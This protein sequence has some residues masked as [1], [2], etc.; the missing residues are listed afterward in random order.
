MSI[1]ALAS[2]AA[3]LLSLGF[4]AYLIRIARNK[5]WYDHQ[6]ERKIHDG[7]IPRLGGA[8]FASAYILVVLALSV[9]GITQSLGLRI[10][11]VLVALP[12][13]LVFGVVD[14]FRP[15]RPR[16]KLLVQSIAALL[17]L[18][19]QFIF[20]RLS[21]TSIG[22]TIPFGWLGYPITFFWLVGV[23]NAVN[24]ID[25]VDGLAGGVSVIIAVFLA[26][27]FS[28][29]GNTAA[30]ILCGVLAATIVGFLVFNLP[31]PKAKIFMGDGGSQFLGFTL[32]MLPLLDNGSGEASL[33]LP[34]AAALLIVP[35]FDTFMAIWRRLRDGRRIDSADR[36]HMHHKLMNLGLGARGVDA[37][38]Y[39]LQA[40]VGMLVYLSVTS[41]GLMPLFYL[42]GAYALALT[43][44][45][46]LHYLNRTVMA[47][48]A[49]AKEAGR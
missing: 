20:H 28:L 16:Y 32:A 48:Q 9:A 5:N 13:I 44:F 38:V 23:T 41:T 4:V 33:P 12:L 1:Y 26:A 15:L 27:V 40:T 43:F 8:G 21:F 37:V 29:K 36:A 25:G 34:F 45:V 30:A 10:I 2:S 18:S 14:D 11:P 7:Q 3:F 35:I 22:V 42:G 46:G 47:R 39:S 24:L 6:N 17:V 49:I 31:L 19:A